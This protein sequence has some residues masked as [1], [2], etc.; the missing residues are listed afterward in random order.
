MGRLILL[1]AGAFVAVIVVLW[2]VHALLAL[3]M[4]AVIVAIV[5]AV[6][7]LAFWSGRRS[8]R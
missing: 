3:V 7:R 8:R 6:L 1:L 2:A 4:F 5:L